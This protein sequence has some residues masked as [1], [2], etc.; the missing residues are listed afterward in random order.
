[1]F[2]STEYEYF[3]NSPFNDVFAFLLNGQNIA[4]IPG[5]TPATPIAINTVNVGNS[6]GVYPADASN[7]AWFTRYS[8]TGVT[9]FNWGGAT[10]VFQLSFA[11]QPGQ[12]NT[13]RL[14]IADA[15]DEVLDSAVLIQGGTFSTDPIEPEDTVT[16]EPSTVILLAGGLL[17]LMVRNRRRRTLPA[18]T[19]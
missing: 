1:M 14:S 9:P 5:V 6:L 13:I 18:E 11:I 2:A 7:P 16:P 19:S 12:T 17:V 4:L 10:R 15:S 3:V 8:E